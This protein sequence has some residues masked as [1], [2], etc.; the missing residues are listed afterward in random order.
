[1]LEA[2]WFWAVLALLVFRLVWGLVGGRWSRFGAFLYSPA[3]LVR[4]LRGAGHPFLTQAHGR[5]PKE[6]WNHLD[7]FDGSMPPGVRDLDAKPVAAAMA[8]TAR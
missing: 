6:V 3:R 4:Y 7:C 1:M 8:S 5:Q 2:A